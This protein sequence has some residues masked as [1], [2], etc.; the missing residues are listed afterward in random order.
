MQSTN[1]PEWGN[2]KTPWGDI[3][4]VIVIITIITIWYVFDY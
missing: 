3:L 4:G 2:P 1:D